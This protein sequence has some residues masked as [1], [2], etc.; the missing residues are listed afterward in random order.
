[1]SPERQQELLAQGFTPYRASDGRITWQRIAP[2]T[3]GK[4]SSSQ[5][6]LVASTSDGSGSSPLIASRNQRPLLRPQAWNP[7]RRNDGGKD[8]GATTAKESDC[9]DGSCDAAQDTTPSTGTESTTPPAKP[10]TTPSAPPSSTPTVDV[11]KL[12]GALLEAMAKDERFRGP[13]GADG[14]DGKPGERGPAGAPG[15]PGL[16]GKDGKDADVQVVV[17][18]V[19]AQMTR[20]ENISQLAENLPPIRVEVVD[21]SGRVVSS[22]TVSLGG[23]LRLR[24]KPK[25]VAG[26]Q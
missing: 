16:A 19:M 25:V 5:A 9:S 23:T 17:N 14:K 12:A 8:G 22:D 6:P 24:L 26:E 13:A 1:M 4:S 7:A 3:S 21:E 10:E 20:N 18:Q 2:S 15:A 11:D